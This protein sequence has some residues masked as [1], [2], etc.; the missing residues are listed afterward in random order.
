M[1]INVVEGVP[2]VDQ[3]RTIICNYFPVFTCDLS[4]SFLDSQPNTTLT[5]SFQKLTSQNINTNIKLKN[6]I[7]FFKDYVLLDFQ[8]IMQWTHNLY[9]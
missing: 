8:S 1:E 6:C 2:S 7:D 3:S 9:K 5:T 4:L